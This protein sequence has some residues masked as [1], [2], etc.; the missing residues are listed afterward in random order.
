MWGIEKIIITLYK[1]KDSRN[2]K[3]LYKD[4]KRF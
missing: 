1:S 2:F 3:C 4:D